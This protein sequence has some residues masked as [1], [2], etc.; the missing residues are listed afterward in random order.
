V[1]HRRSNF[2]EGANDEELG[3]KE[4]SS[5]SVPRNPVCRGV[6]VDP[7][8]EQPVP[9]EQGGAI[10]ARQN[11]TEGGSVWY[12][13]TEG[14]SSRAERKKTNRA[15]QNTTGGPFSGLKHHYGH[16]SPCVNVEGFYGQSP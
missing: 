7:E 4:E 9:V 6:K 5:S 13:I 12:S 14:N 1:T 11:I 8:P 15:W 3:S 10:P 2:S 16:I